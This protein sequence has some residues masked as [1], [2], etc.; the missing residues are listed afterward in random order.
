ML[1]PA[2]IR[3]LHLKAAV[4]V[5]DAIT[6]CTPQGPRPS[7]GALVAQVGVLFAPCFSSVVLRVRV[8]RYYRVLLPLWVGTFEFQWT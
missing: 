2:R 7:E 3:G 6:N 1:W 5:R 8:R 4:Q